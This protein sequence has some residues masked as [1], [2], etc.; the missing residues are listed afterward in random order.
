[1][2][3]LRL[4]PGAQ[5]VLPAAAGEGTRRKLYFFAGA[6]LTVD[7]HAVAAGSGIEVRAGAAVVLVNGDEVAE[8]LMLQ[9]RPIGEPVAQ[10]G[11]FVM[12]TE[13]ELRQAFEDYRRTQFG[14]WPW[15]DPAPV[16]GDGLDRFA[17]HA[18]GRT[19][20]HPAQE[21]G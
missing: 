17:R 10:Y 14:G 19:E 1:M 4:D 9:G 13:Q 12:N 16:H 20:R 3:T 8:L 2:W 5:W 6:H 11:P 18:D 21:P 7:G 15:P